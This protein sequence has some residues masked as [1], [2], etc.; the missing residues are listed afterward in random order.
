MEAMVA[1]RRTPLLIPTPAR[2]SIRISWINGSL[3]FLPWTAA[4]IVIYFF[5]Y[6]DSARIWNTGDVVGSAEKKFL[7]GLVNRFEH[8]DPFGLGCGGGIL[9]ALH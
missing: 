8:H 5:F 2:V 6:D 3:G 4:G 7:E 9:R 1:R